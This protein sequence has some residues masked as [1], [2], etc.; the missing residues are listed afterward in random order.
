VTVASTIVTVLLAA[1]VSVAA[2]RKLSH[3]ERVVESYRRAG[4]PEDKLNILAVIL[5]AGAAGL[6]LGRLWSPVGVAAAIGLI[7]YFAAAV[8][9]HIRAGDAGR[10]ATPIGYG[11]VAVAALVLQVAAR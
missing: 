1:L 3:T 7:G 11:A 4:V 9:A 10:L 8:A 5:L 2:V 6:L